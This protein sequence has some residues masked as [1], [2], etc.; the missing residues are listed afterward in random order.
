MHQQF[1]NSVIDNDVYEHDY[2]VFMGTLSLT[3]QVLQRR[4]RAGIALLNIWLSI[5]TDNYRDPILGHIKLQWW[6]DCITNQQCD[7][8][9]AKET[10]RDILQHGDIM[11]VLI[12]M[13]CFLETPPNTTDE[14]Q[15][16]LN[17]TFGKIGK[18]IHNDDNANYMGYG[19]IKC[20]QMGLKPPSLPDIWVNNNSGIHRINKIVRSIGKKIFD[21]HKKIH[22][23]NPVILIRLWLG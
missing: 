20:R 2:Y 10:P 11:D 3:D 18:I 19:V 8:P 14:W 22:N 5:I 7:H 21:G 13:R 9:V 6:A 12:A 16:Y 15:S 1:I 23:K 17:Q 4:I